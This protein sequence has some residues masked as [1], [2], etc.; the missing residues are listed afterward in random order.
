MRTTL[1]LDDDLAR[2]LKD[3]A[4]EQDLPFK[5]VV[6]DAVR[7]GLAASNGSRQPYRMTPMNLRLRPDV[8]YTKALQMAADLEDAAIIRKL[9]QGR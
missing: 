8:D 7:A 3:R 6:N 2:L 4:R 1:T 9:Q 5:Q